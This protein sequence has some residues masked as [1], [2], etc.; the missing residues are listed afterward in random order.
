M[1]VGDEKHQPITLRVGTSSGEEASQ[2][3]FTKR[4]HD[5][6]DLADFLTLLVV[7]HTAELVALAPV[8]L[9]LAPH[10]HSTTPPLPTLRQCWEAGSRISLHSGFVCSLQFPLVLP[11]DGQDCSAPRPHHK[12]RCVSGANRPAKS[13]ASQSAS[14]HPTRRRSYPLPVYCATF[15]SL[16]SLSMVSIVFERERFS[17]AARASM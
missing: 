14:I 12:R 11:L 5:Y 8:R 2:L 16:A 17:F 3:F 6:L 10:V 4:F 9:L 7:I 1:V 13:G 15:A